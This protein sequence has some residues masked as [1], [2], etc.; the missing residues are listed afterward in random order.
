[1]FATRQDAQTPTGLFISEKGAL[2]AQVNRPDTES[3]QIDFFYG[4]LRLE[5]RE[6]VPRK[7]IRDFTSLPDAAREVEAVL[8][9]RRSET[10]A[11]TS[12][13]V[14]D[15]CANCGNKGHDI[16]MCRKRERAEKSEKDSKPGESVKAE[17]KCYGCGKPGV[18]KRNCP[19]CSPPQDTAAQT[20]VFHA[21]SIKPTERPAVDITVS[22]I[23]GRAFLDPGA[24]TSLASP[25]L[26]KV[27]KKL[28]FPFTKQVAK[29]ILADG[30]AENKL[31]Q[32]VMVPVTLK[33]R[34]FT[35]PFVCTEGG[36]EA[37]TLLGVD[38]A[39]L[40][41]LVVNYHTNT[42]H[43]HG[44]S[45]EEYAFVQKENHPVLPLSP[46]N[47]VQ[48]EPRE[49]IVLD[50]P[51]QF[52][53]DFDELMKSDEWSDLTE[54]YGLVIAPLP[55]TSTRVSPPTIHVQQRPP[56]GRTDAKS[57]SRTNHRWADTTYAVDLE[58]EDSPRRALEISV[59]T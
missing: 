48:P 37:A 40:A 41:K 36:S 19:L 51:Y 30:R 39:R 25:K 17:V 29:L 9:E 33:G 52:P 28:G 55:P 22:G 4:L 32:T 35:T 20:L 24:R 50:D 15:K 26:Q 2:L 53:V 42:Y 13:K 44:A 46:F 31:I 14:R 43:F 34:T 47:A 27:L 12:K 10:T 45:H 16:T 54:N 1:V 5:I 6:R 7:T 23:P 8:R 3:R 38:F 56:H 49:E 18:T 57:F 59:L 21:L 11:E 58:Y